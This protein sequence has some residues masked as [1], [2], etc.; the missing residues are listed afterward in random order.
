MKWLF[1]LLQAVASL[2]LESFCCSWA[3][4]YILTCF[5][6]FMLKVTPLEKH[7]C[8]CMPLWLFLQVKIV[9]LLLLRTSRENDRQEETLRAQAQSLR[10]L[11]TW[12]IKIMGEVLLNDWWYE[13]R[14][15]ARQGRAGVCVADQQQLYSSISAMKIATHVKVDVFTERRTRVK[16]KQRPL[17]RESYATCKVQAPI[18]QGCHI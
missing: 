13:V 16:K 5:W 10:G 8:E 9:S 1:V 7:L 3:L 2:K 11:E 6:K 4:I 14:E 15:G 17:K 18:K 12:R